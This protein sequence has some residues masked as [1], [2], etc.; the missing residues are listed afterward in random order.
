M[1]SFSAVVP[2]APN[3]DVRRFDCG[4][5]EINHFLHHQ[6]TVEQALG[7]SQVYVS[8]SIE[9]RVLAYFTLSPVAVRIESTLLTLM[10]V[11]AVAYPTVGGFLLGRLGVNASLQGH[12]VG[13]ALVMRAAQIAKQEAAVVGGVFL[14]VDPKTDA[15]VRWYARQEFVHLGG[16][17]RRMILPLCAVPG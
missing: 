5:A 7:L 1:N 11:R 10:G 15:L 13:E 9:S 6:A 3:H 17:G 12:G 2:F 4:D 8:A 14:A 16:K